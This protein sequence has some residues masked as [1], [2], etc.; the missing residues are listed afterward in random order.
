MQGKA[1]VDAMAAVYVG[2]DVCKARLD[3][4]LHPCGERFAVANDAGGRRRLR[5]RLDKLAVA[6]VVIEAT[7]KYH[8]AVHRHL[9]A[10]AI[11]VAVVNPLRARL[12]AEASGIFAKTDAID[13]RTLALMGARLDPARTP[14]VSRIVEALDE[15]VR[16]RSAAIDE[17]VA[18]ANRRDN[19]ATPFLRI[20]LARRIRALDTHV[21]RIEARIS[22]LV[23]QDPHMAA[24]HAI[25]RSIPGIGPV[26]AATLCAGLNELGRVDAKQVAALA[27]LAPF[28]TDSGPKNGQRHIR[29][30]RPHI[31]KAL[32]MAALSAC[33]FNPDLKRF[34]ASL[35]A[36][37][38]PP[39]VAITAVM[40][41]LLVLAN[42]LVAQNRPWIPRPA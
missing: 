17:R 26:N 3:V 42:S 9:D 32:Y 22:H 4:Y 33:R 8:R 27:G 36:N 20:E 10:A 19:T 14:P 39:K 30:G 13:A 6:L 12:F 29:G 34:H 40:R 35:I 5:R 11:R 38:K 7:S 1:H 25:L 31:R 41:K 37:G 2:I 24:R 15:L 16:A 21:R 18:L 23:A 28:A